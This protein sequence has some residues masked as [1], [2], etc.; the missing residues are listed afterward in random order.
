VEVGKTEARLATGGERLTD[1]ALANGWFVAPTVFR[2]VDPQARIAQEEVFGP[3]VAA[4]PFSDLDHAAGIANSTR[5][6][7]AAGVFTKDIDKAIALARR[8]RAG[9]VWVNTYAQLFQNSEMGGMRESGQGRQ[10]GLDG[11]HEYT[12]LKNIAIGIDPR[13]AP[14]A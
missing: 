9:T 4:M 13:L 5:Y 12:E 3:V 8:V 2:D 7:L 14:G 1:G 10:Y 6:G 11:L